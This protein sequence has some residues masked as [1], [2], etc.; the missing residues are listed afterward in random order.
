LDTCRAEKGHI[1][2][3]SKELE[4]LTGSLRAE[5]EATGK[6]LRASQQSC[7]EMQ[8]ETDLLVFRLNEVEELRAR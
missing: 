6:E 1:E 2:G 3:L 7:M 5:L 4:A 8:R